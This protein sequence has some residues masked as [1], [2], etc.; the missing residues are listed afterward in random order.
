MSKKVILNIQIYAILNAKAEKIFEAQGIDSSYVI[1]VIYNYV[2]KNK[3]LP[4][5]VN[6]PSKQT[7][8][9]INELESGKGK[10]FKNIKS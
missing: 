6:V 8:D 10:K 4:F 1:N 3:K 5:D 7:I 2:E 9:V